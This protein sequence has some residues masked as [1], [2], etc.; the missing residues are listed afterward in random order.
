MQ[1]SLVL[2]T[3]GWQDGGRVLA[4]QKTM[5]QQRVLPRAKA[6]RKTE[7]QGAGMWSRCVR[8]TRM[9]LAPIDNMRHLD[10]DSWAS[11]QT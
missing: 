3:H 9:W 4:R 8:C 1:T 10:V 5:Q 7:S 11:Q 6:V 2:P